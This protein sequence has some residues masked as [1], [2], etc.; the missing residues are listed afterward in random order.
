MGKLFST[1]CS[2]HEPP[3]YDIDLV[4]LDIP[5]VDAQQQEL[6]SGP[7]NKPVSLM[8]NSGIRSKS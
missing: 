3:T 6:D 5:A 2:A 7:P 1:L 8:K 4:I